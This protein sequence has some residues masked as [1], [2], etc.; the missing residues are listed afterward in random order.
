M[1]RPDAAHGLNINPEL[2]PERLARPINRAALVGGDCRDRRGRVGVAGTVRYQTEGHQG[3]PHE[4]AELFA[5]P[6]VFVCFAISMRFRQYRRVWPG[7][8]NRGLNRVVPRE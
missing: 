5:I 2:P 8:R 3:V 6:P 1:V 4:R 7:R